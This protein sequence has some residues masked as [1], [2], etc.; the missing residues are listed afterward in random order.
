[1]AIHYPPLNISN[2]YASGGSLLSLHGSVVMRI[3]GRMF[4]LLMGAVQAG[5]TAKVASRPQPTMS[6]ARGK[7]AAT[8]ADGANFS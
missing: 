7:P 8:C 2:G 4:G 6:V 3:P 1:M 5:L